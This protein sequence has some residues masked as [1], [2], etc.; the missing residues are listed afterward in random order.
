MIE[1]VREVFM[2]AEVGCIEKPYPDIP[3]WGFFA[4]FIVIH[5]GTEE[6]RVWGKGE[7]KRGQAVQS[8]IAMRGIS[9]RGIPVRENEPSRDLTRCKGINNWVHDGASKR[10]VTPAIEFGGHRDT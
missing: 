7:G 5:L 2:G 6:V 9:E 4:V 8:R 10:R 3:V 1:I